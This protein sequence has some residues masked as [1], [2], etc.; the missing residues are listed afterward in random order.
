VNGDITTKSIVV[1]E[2]ARINGS[3]RMT[4][5]SPVSTSGNAQP[6]Q[7]VGTRER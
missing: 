5:L 1:M 2:G 4:E 7:A 6:A 3:V